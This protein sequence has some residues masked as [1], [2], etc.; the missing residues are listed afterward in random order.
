MDDLALDTAASE[1]IGF[2]TPLSPV[3]STKS[4]RKSVRWEDI[5]SIKSS[6]SEEKHE[7]SFGLG[8]PW[9]LS[10]GND[11]GLSAEPV[12][13][14]AEVRLIEVLSMLRFDS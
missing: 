10:G 3:S 13:N 5:E 12:D 4:K 14:L 6:P 7:S 11:D 1:P 9:L 2:Q 8:A